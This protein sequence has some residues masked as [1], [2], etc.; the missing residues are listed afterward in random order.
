MTLYDLIFKAGGFE[1]EEFKKRTYLKRAELV[2][3]NEDN[4]EKEIISFNLGLVLNK[5]GLSNTVL[6]TDDAVQIY[7]VLEIEGTT[8]SVTISGYVKNME[9]IQY[10]IP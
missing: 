9:P 7:S 6:R 1:D 10:V 8:G 5:Q 3:V 4:D 2:R